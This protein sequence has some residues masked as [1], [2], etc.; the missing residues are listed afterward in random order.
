MSKRNLCLES[1]RERDKYREAKA[2]RSRQRQRDTD[3]G[4]GCRDR[5]MVREAARQRL[6]DTETRNRHTC[7]QTDKQKIAEQSGAGQ[8]RAKQSSGAV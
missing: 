7:S 5:C 3:R 2:K 8:S 1:E 6:R 4:S